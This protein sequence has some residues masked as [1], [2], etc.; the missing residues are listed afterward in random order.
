M[1]RFTAD[2]ARNLAN[3]DLDQRIRQAVSNADAGPNATYMRVYCDDPWLHSLESELR[4]RGFINIDVPN[5][6]IKGDVY[7]EWEGQ[8]HD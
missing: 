1:T 2:D 5:I 8:S 3:D 6:T 4:D 7:F